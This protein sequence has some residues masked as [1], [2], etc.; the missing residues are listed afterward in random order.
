MKL[1]AFFVGLALSL[2]LGNEL[3]YEEKWNE[4]WL[5]I[6]YGKSLNSETFPYHPTKEEYNK[7]VLQGAKISFDVQVVT[8]DGT[9]VEGATVSGDLTGDHFEKKDN[10]VFR[11]ETDSKGNVHIEGKCGGLVMFHATKEGW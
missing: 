11:K 5:M 8:E 2:V 6:N 1:I 10:V 9:V 7:A 3:M 4:R